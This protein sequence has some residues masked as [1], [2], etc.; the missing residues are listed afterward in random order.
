MPEDQDPFEEWEAMRKEM[1]ETWGIDYNNFDPSDYEPPAPDPFFDA[2]ADPESTPEQIL[3]LLKKGENPNRTRVGEYKRIEHPATVAASHPN[4]EILDLLLKA[5]ADPNAVDQHGY[6]PLFSA[7]TTAHME[8]LFSHG[9]TYPQPTVYNETPLQSAYLTPDLQTLRFLLERGAP[10]SELGA[11]LLHLALILGSPSLQEALPSNLSDIE[12]SDSRDRTPL[13]LALQT[14]NTE[15][16]Q[17]LLNVGASPT[18]KDHVGR[19]AIHLAAQSDSP[20][21]IQLAEKY[22]L[23]IDETDKFQHTPLVTA[24][25]FA[26][27]NS[28]SYLMERIKDCPDYYSQ[29]DQALSSAADPQVASLFVAAGANMNSINSEVRQEMNPAKNLSLRLTDVSEARYK[30]GRSPRFGRINPEEAHEP[31]WQAMIICRANGY[32]ARTQFNDPARF[33]CGANDPVWCADRFGQ[34]ITPLPDGRII[35]I[36]GEHED[37]YDPDFCIYNDVFVHEP[38]KLPRVFTY[39]RE[40]FPPTDFHTATL[41]GD[42]IYIIGSLGYTE[43]RNLNKCPVYRLNI[44]TLAIE[45]VETAGDEP[46][47][48]YKHRG[49]K[50]SEFEILVRDGGKCA[51]SQKFD[52]PYQASILN[53]KSNAWTPYMS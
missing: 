27:H 47:R 12:N 43:D 42:W 34:S 11:S 13:L 9:A 16:A 8:L 25:E 49:I 14:G 1:E 10:I 40:V 5:G 24:V 19:T 22:G 35:E 39:P 20:E 15:A 3:F 26:A 38:G 33:A 53:I 44:Q 30:S 17:L 28:I 48:I 52:A 32:Q 18:A 7:Q 31:F 2:L 37:S 23:D 41:M 29:I 21:A 4:T 36:A 45:S 6:T 50:L 46:G 51:T